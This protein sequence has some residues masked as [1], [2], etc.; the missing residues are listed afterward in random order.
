[1]A[2]FQPQYKIAVGNNNAAGLTALESITPAGDNNFAPLRI[3]WNYNPGDRRI[4]AD[5]TLYHA[6]FPSQLWRARVLTKLQWLYLKDTYC[7]SGYSGAVTIRTRFGDPDTYANYNAILTLPK[8]IDTTQ[9]SRVYVDV[10]LVFTRLV[11]L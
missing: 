8:E 4:R 1:M 6:G 9:T 11:A 5:G 10:D 2:V 3:Y 7:N